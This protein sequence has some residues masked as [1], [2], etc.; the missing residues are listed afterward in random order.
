MGTLKSRDC[1][2]FIVIGEK[3]REMLIFKIIA[4][5]VVGI[6]MA[7]FYINVIQVFPQHLGIIGQA[8]LW[9]TFLSLVAIHCISDGDRKVKKR[10]DG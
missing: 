7:Y 9:I 8:I 3:K 10:D 1:G 6:F 5:V 4:S 2:D